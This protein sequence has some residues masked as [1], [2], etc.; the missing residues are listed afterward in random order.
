M[1]INLNSREFQL[2]Y[3]G[4]S[5]TFTTTQFVAMRSLELLGKLNKTG[6]L[7]GGDISGAYTLAPELLAGTFARVVGEDGGVQLDSRGK[8]DIIF[9]GPG[10]LAALFKVMKHAIE[11]NYADFFEENARALEEA[12][13]QAEAPQQPQG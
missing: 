5:V 6:V 1:E 11:V 12:R 4:R 9:S 3:G 7:D 13:A 8:L 2:Q 10:G